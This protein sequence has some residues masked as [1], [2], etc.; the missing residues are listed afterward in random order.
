MYMYHFC[1]DLSFLRGYVFFLFPHGVV[2][3]VFQ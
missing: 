3:N 2:F 1:I